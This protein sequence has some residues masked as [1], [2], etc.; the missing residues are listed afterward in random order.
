MSHQKLIKLISALVQ[1]DR[2][3]MQL[4]REAFEPV[5][6]CRGHVLVEAG[7]ISRYMYF[8]NTGFLR[9]YYINQEGE[10]VTSHINCPMD[11]MTAFS[12]YVSQ[13]ASGETFECIT[14]CQLLRI[15]HNELETLIRHN[16]RWSEFGKIVYEEVIRYN[17]EKAR[18][19]VSL[20]AEQRYLK[21]LDRHPDIVQHVPLQY[22][23]SFIGIKP[24]SLSRIR[25]RIIT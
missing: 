20:T 12:S 5:G 11:F 2:S 3:D 7:S 25:R 16:Q 1:I 24:E 21:L 17:E 18:D 15:R 8:I 10:E 14:D 23:A 9:L 22:I 13:A 4:L 19:L 6:Y